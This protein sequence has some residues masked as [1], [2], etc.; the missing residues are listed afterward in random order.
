MKTYDERFV[1]LEKKLA[2]TVEE[3]QSRCNSS[4]RIYFDA[5]KNNVEG[6][7]QLRL[8]TIATADMERRDIETG[9]LKKEREALLR[10]AAQAAREAIRSLGADSLIGINFRVNFDVK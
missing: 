3:N 4:M 5:V 10:E 8:L 1:E 6:K 7:E 2:K 9:S